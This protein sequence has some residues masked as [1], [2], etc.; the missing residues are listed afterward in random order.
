MNKNDYNAIENLVLTT[1]AQVL[2][3]NPCPSIVSIM[4]KLPYTAQTT[5][6]DIIN[7]NINIG[8]ISEEYIKN[9]LNKA[10]YLYSCEDGI[11]NEAQ[12]TIMD[13]FKILIK[14]KE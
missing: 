2:R 6:F 7:P 8:I 11:I 9:V 5:C 1:Y 10:K 12:N 13:L 4:N 3:T 14:T